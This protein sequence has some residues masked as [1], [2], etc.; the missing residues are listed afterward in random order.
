M[1][2]KSVLNPLLIISLITGTPALA[3]NAG[4]LMNMFTAIMGAAIVN[5][6]R[7]EWSKVQANETVCIEQELGHQGVSIGGLIQ[8]GIAPNDPR[9]AGIR[10]DCRTAALPPPSVAPNTR[11]VTTNPNSE[12][13]GSLSKHPTFD[14]SKAR[15]L[16]ASTMCSDE[17]GA[18][19]DWDLITAYWARYFSL[20]EGERQ[21]FDKAQQDWLDS[22]NRKCPRAQ[23]A[24]QC[25]LAAYH[26][27][28]ASYR[29]GLAGEALAESRLSPEQHARIQQSA[30]QYG[31]FDR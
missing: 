11:S 31:I 13:I 6:A 18:S 9:I 23:N 24:Q 8:N 30:N 28:A 16:T 1:T 5:N 3:Q 20:P 22:L 7:I 26:K 25:V 4:G 14:C 17:A 12:N 15:S 10:F 2:R 27:R 21:S 19:A 29:S